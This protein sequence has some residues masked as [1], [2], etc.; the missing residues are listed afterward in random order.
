MQKTAFCGPITLEIERRCHYHSAHTM[1]YPQRPIES[2]SIFES[3]PRLMKITALLLL[4][5]TLSLTQTAIA[6]G[7]AEQGAAIG[8]SCLGCH[9]IEGYNNVYPTYHVPRLGGQ[10]RAYVESALRA[11]RD[12]TRE[13]PTMAAQGGSLS[14]TD[15]EN[16]GAWLEGFGTATDSATS[17]SVA[18]IE[19]AKACVACHGEAGVGV[20]PQPPTLSGQHQ[21]Y[22]QAALKQ[23]KEG[24]R[25]GTIMS[26]FAATLSEEDID[27]VARYYASQDGLTT[28][29]TKE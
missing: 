13:H 15:I 20:V 10:K 4:V 14:D 26:A 11:Y 6:E 19:A 7:D 5:S 16:I 28:P 29:A 27:E 17:D 8:Y 21:D 25:S 24:T 9:G 3:E 22:L 23:Y 1:L 12:G 2:R 18:D